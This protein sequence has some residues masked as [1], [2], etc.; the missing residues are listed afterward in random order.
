MF[1]N[2]SNFAAA[3][4]SP[5]PGTYHLPACKPDLKNA[6][7]PIGD[8]VVGELR[9]VAP[10]AAIILGISALFLLLLLAAVETART[11]L[12]KVIAIVVGIGALAGAGIT[13][14]TT[15]VQPGC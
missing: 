3:P 5:S 13:I 15:F 10:T 4:P 1:D 11:R 12:L 8:L 2:L 9:G 7:T 14:I 6:I